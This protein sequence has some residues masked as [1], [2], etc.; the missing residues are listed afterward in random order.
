MYTHIYIYVDLGELKVNLKLSDTIYL[1]AF[2]LNN[3]IPWFKF[4]IELLM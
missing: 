2:K 1:H 4:P 3:C